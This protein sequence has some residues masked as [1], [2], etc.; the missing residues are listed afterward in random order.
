MSSFVLSLRKKFSIRT[1]IVD[2][3]IVIC[4]IQQPGI[5][6]PKRQ[7]Q[8]VVDGV[9][10]DVVPENVTLQGLLE[11]FAAAFKTFEEVCPAKAHQAFARAREIVELLRF[12]LCWWFVRLRSDVVAKAVSRQVHEVDRVND[13]RGVEPR[14]LVFGICL[15]D[16]EA[17][18]ARH[19]IRKI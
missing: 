14:I 12:L 11:G 10:E 16:R 7:R 17:K 3:L 9:K 4:G 19:P 2:I 6:R 1:L 8:I 18:C 15:V 13:R 5:L